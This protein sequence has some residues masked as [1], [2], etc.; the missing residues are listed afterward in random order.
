LEE[1]FTRTGSGTLIEREPF[2][3]LDFPA[4][5]KQL[6]EIVELRRECSRAA[7]PSGV[8]YLKPL[9]TEELEQRLPTTIVLR[10]RDLIVGTVYFHE[11]PG[12]DDT[13]VIGGFA[14]GENHQD[15]GY[16]RV[17]IESALEQIDEAGYSRA[18]SITA[19]ESVKHMYEHYARDATTDWPDIL[20]QARARYGPDSDLVSV[21]EFR[22]PLATP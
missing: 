4:L 22:L 5:P 17:L 11:A 19:A 14:V 8:P 9:S 2:L 3:E 13:A 18:I 6:P 12:H 7:T 20:A 16:G 15:S 21:Y 1:L 10:Q